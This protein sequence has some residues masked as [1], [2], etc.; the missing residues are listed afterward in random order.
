MQDIDE[1]K[2]TATFL[3]ELEGE[4]DTNKPAPEIQEKSPNKPDSKENLTPGQKFLLTLLF[5]FF[6]LIAGFFLMLVTG[7]MVIPV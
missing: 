6:I 7:K 4:E 1:F 3:D 5:F 2:K